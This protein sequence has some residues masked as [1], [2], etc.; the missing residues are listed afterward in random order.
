MDTVA[1][2]VAFAPR[3]LGLPVEEHCRLALASTGL[4]SF[5]GRSPTCLS[6]GEQQRTAL[7]AV[8]SASPRLLILD[9]PTIGQDWGHLERLMEYLRQLRRS[10]V[11]VLLITHDDKLVRRFAERILCLQEGRLSA[12][13]PVGA[14]PA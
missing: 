7:A 14:R 2:E 1:E 11:S 9:E 10:G 3:N 6:L 8:L 13:G 5:V 12:D 4:S